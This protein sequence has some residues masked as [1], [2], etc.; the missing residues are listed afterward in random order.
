[1]DHLLIL[2]V[3]GLIALVRKLFLEG[4]LARILE[5][6]RGDLDPS[7]NDPNR[8]TPPMIRRQATFPGSSPLSPEE[9]RMRKFRE[10]LGLP[11][12]EELITRK[13]GNYPVPPI[14]AGPVRQPARAR[15]YAREKRELIEKKLAEKQRAL[16]ERMAQPPP[17]LP[18]KDTAVA[19][20]FELEQFDQPQLATDLAG[21]S[22]AQSE[23]IPSSLEVQT[24]PS[25]NLQ[26]TRLAEILGSSSDL[27]RLI[28]AQE[29]FGRP[30]SLQNA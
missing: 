17:P 29:I 22:R 2:L 28:L 26:P 7:G 20:Y 30:K 10:A 13:A 24:H 12:D 9:E 16:R 11:P 23:T 15:D 8:T 6:L 14:V 27:R 18:A 5:K 1:M 4:G 19:K 25:P 3:V 21:P